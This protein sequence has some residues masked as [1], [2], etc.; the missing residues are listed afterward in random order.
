[1]CSC[2]EVAA[3]YTPF[4]LAREPAED[5]RAAP[6]RDRY[7]GGPAL[8]LKLLTALLAKQNS[9]AREENAHSLKPI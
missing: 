2:G 9:T 3:P 6:Q 5:E 7:R 4:S 8:P 1:M